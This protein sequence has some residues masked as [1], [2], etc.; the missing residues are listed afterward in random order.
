LFGAGTVAAAGVILGSI[1]AVEPGTNSG[2]A[3]AAIGSF[4]ATG[5][6][7]R[8]T[9]P[10]PPMSVPEVEQPQFAVISIKVRKLRACILA[11]P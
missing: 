8:G 10:S 7:A 6:W 5:A 9:S 11:T 4:G 1:F 3:G 2:M